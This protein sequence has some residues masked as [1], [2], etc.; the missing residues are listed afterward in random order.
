MREFKSCSTFSWTMFGSYSLI[1]RV[2]GIVF[3]TDK[4]VG[5]EFEKGLVDLKKLVEKRFSKAHKL[6]SL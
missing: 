1:N 5:S 6:D 3:N 2:F 4:M